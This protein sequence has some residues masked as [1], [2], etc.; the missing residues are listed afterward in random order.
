MIHNIYTSR[1]AQ[2][3]WINRTGEDRKLFCA[4]LERF[5]KLKSIF[6]RDVTSNE[7]RDWP[8]PPWPSDIPPGDL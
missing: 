5:P 2:E 6:F 3:E 4:A 1:H 8:R 7:D